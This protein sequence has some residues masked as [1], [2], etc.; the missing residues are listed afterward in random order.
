MHVSRAARG[1][2]LAGSCPALLWRTALAL[3]LVRRM[4]EGLLCPLGSQTV[5]CHRVTLGA[6]VH[7]LA[8][9][10]EASCEVDGSRVSEP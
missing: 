9:P 5:T 7:T 4:E 10:E 1:R 3:G 6:S 8:L 2:V